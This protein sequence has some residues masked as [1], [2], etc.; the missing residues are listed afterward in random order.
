MGIFSGLSY[1]SNKV[2]YPI[3]TLGHKVG[4]GVG[5]IG[6][7]FSSKKSLSEEN[8]ILRSKLAEEEAS[9]L[10]YNTILAENASLKEAFGRKSENKKL[11]LATILAK[12]NQ[13]PYDTLLVDAGTN[14]GLK[15][16]NLVL[17][18]GNIP[19]GKIAETYA[20]SSKVILFSNSGEKTQTLIKDGV[21]VDLVGRGGGNFEM[22]L[23]RDFMIA[24]G[25]QAVLPGISSYVLAVMETVIS[26][27]RDAFEKALFVSP[28]NI[29]QI[30]FVQIEL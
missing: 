27:P 7:Y 12:P 1:A 4:S 16:G 23:P 6:A 28:V 11:I 2:F 30:K 10:N 15:T 22:I 24:K 20:D 17:A 3:I 26:D 5:G 9:I 19:I 25:D 14:D 21:A 13:T 29:Q 8:L 18:N